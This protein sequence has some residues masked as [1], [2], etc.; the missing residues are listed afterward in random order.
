MV[1]ERVV[2]LQA[3]ASPSAGRGA[4]AEEA[5]LDE[6]DAA[7]QSEASAVLTKGEGRGKR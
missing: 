7:L 6:V 1:V 2:V 3:L 4:F 5:W